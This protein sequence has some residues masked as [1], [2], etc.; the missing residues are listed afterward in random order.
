MSTRNTP[1]LEY[2]RVV[3]LSTDPMPKRK[4]L[5]VLILF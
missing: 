3:R 2:A 1:G 5:V 4:E